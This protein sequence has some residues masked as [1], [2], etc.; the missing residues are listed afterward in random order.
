MKH[1]IADALVFKK[2]RNKMGGNL[3]FMPCGGAAISPE[4]TKFFDAL[5]DSYYSWLWIDRDC[6]CLSHVC[7]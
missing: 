4:V 7:L 6:S 1:K 2:V 5:G 3:W